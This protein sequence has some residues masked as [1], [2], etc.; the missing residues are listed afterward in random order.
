MTRDQIQ[1]ECKKLG[2]EAVDRKINNIQA[3][4][5]KINEMDR[6]LVEKVYKVEKTEDPQPTAEIE[7]FTKSKARIALE[8]DLARLKE[9]QKL[10]ALKIK[11]PQED[12]GKKRKA[13]KAEAA[14]V[15]LGGI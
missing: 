5:Y 9:K 6:G 15:P 14:E 11:Q 4:I 3:I 12:T 2:I 8:A 13:S 10:L 1:E 7:Y